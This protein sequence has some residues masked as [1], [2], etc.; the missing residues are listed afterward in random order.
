MLP[1][2]MLSRPLETLQDWSLHYGYLDAKPLWMVQGN[3]GPLHLRVEVG[4]FKTIWL[5]GHRKEGLKHA[6]FYLDRNVPVESDRSMYV[7]S[8]KREL[9]TSKAPVGPEC[10]AINDLPQGKHVLS[11]ETPKA[12]EKHVHELSHVIMWP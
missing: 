7:Q 10:V 4:S 9:W 5:C 12:P 2:P 3:Q 6:E 11:I 8:S 1:L